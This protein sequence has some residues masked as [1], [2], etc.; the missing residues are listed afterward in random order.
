MKTQTSGYSILTLVNR[1]AFCVWRQNELKRAIQF[2]H[3]GDRADVFV[4]DK[5]NVVQACLA[6]W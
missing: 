6:Q 2:T 4:I 5:A 1:F 3:P